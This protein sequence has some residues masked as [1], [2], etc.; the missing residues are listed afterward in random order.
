MNPATAEILRARKIF[1]WSEFVFIL[2][3]PS[4][5]KVWKGTTLSL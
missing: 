5:Q 4:K 3:W 1:C 2:L